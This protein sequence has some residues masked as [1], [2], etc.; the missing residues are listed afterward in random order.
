MVAVTTKVGNTGAQTMMKVAARSWFHSPR[1]LAISH[2]AGG[3]KRAVSSGIA[4]GRTE[5]IQFPSGQVELE[6]EG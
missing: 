4:C 3:R 1:R 2:A 5:R 6:S